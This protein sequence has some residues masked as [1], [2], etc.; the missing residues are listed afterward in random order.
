MTAPSHTPE[1]PAADA[2]GGITLGRRVLNYLASGAG[3]VL[4]L[5][6][7]ILV[8]IIAKNP[9][10]GEPEALVNSLHKA[11]PLLLLAIGQYFVIVVG[12][13]DLS[14]GAIVTTQAAIAAVLLNKQDEGT[15][16]VIALMLVVGLAVGLVNGLII[17]LLKVPSFIATLAMMLVLVGA[18]NLW[19]GGGIVKGAL[20]DEFRKIGR[21]LFGIENVPGVGTISWAVIIVVVVGVLA[22]FLMKS[23]FGR[24]LMVTGDNDKAAAFAGSRTNVTKIAAFMLSSVIATIAA[25]IL[26]GNTSSTVDLSIGNGLEFQAITAVVLGGVVLGGGAGSLFAAILGALTLYFIE[27][28]FRELGVSPE[29]RPA[30]QGF[31]LIVAVAYA[32][33][34]GS[35]R[36]RKGTEK[37]QS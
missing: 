24:V 1:A 31:I 4:V 32:A 14:V 22:G 16:G 9:S 3:I 10:A 29:L 37:R 30:V 26:A 13:F 7:A 34:S 18:T 19:T 25:I 33:R 8:V 15:Y 20:S 35:L 12:E 2:A 28:L 23:S 11:T 27:P 36:R 21:P 17:T 6:I 5:L